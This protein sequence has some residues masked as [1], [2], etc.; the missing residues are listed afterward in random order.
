MTVE[1]NKTLKVTSVIADKVTTTDVKTNNPISGG[2]TT[3]PSIYTSGSYDGST[4]VEIDIDDFDEIDS[5]SSFVYFSFYTTDGGKFATGYAFMDPEGGS[6]NILVTNT[7]GVP[8][9]TVTLLPAT[10]KIQIGNLPVQTGATYYFKAV[11]LA[12]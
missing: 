6:S 2:E 3:L 5:V 9:P 4:T 12:Y 1:L 8:T 7:S 11:L 10:N